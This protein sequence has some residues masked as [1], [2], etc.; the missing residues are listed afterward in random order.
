M[1]AGWKPNRSEARSTTQT[2]TGCLLSTQR[3]DKGGGEGGTREGVYTTALEVVELTPPS[4]VPHPCPCPCP[5]PPPNSANI[6]YV[7]R[8]ARQSEKESIRARRRAW[9][10]QGRRARLI[11]PTTSV[12][13]PQAP[14]TTL[15]HASQRRVLPIPTLTGRGRAEGGRHLVAHVR[16]QGG[17]SAGSLM[18]GSCRR[19]HAST[20]PCS[21]MRALRT[22]I[23]WRDRHRDSAPPHFIVQARGVPPQWRWRKC[24][25]GGGVPTA[26]ATVANGKSGRDGLHRHTRTLLGPPRTV[27]VCGVAND[28]NA[29]FGAV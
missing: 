6:E 8:E 13:T 17:A 7:G 19:G 4:P 5:P 29:G 3:E 11:A 26:A 24:E 9:Q 16:G 23:A 15:Q 21:A 27:V 14:T 22:G 12:R 20:T 28:G 1:R 18:G 2:Q 10:G 25:A